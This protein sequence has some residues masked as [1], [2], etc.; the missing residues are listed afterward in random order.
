MKIAQLAPLVESVPP[1]YYGGTERV[2][3]YLTEALVE[4]GHDVTLFASA[5]SKTSATL[6]PQSPRSFRLDKNKEDHMPYYILMHE[7]IYQHASDFDILHSHMDYALYSMLRHLKQPFVTTLH[8]RLDLSSLRPIYDEFHDT[9]LISISNNQRKPFPNVNWQSTVYN[10]LPKDLY[11]CDEKEGKYLAFI[12]RISPEKRPDLAVE[13]A[14]K[15]DMP[16]KIAAKIDKVDEAYYE[17]EIKSLFKHALVEY[18]GEISEDEKNEF[19]GNAYALIFPID[20]PEPFG[21]AMI[22][23]M[24]CGTP[25]IARKCGSVPEVIE[26]GVNGFIFETVDEA[27]KKIKNISSLNRLRVR[28]TFEKKFTSRHMAENYVKSYEKLISNT[29]SKV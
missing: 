16:L 19:L 6:K 23:A 26:E 8:G 7:N 28:D 24:A 22:E 18:I 17:S 5:D 20:W 27:I 25:V 29:Q 14:K 13:I 10:G 15:L 11:H 3:S 1:K 2:I 21:L 9:P 4:M 12:G